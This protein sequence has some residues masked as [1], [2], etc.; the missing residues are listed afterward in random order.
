MADDSVDEDDGWDR[1]IAGRD[2]VPALDARRLPV[3]AARTVPLPH[4]RP[5]TVSRID[6]DAADTGAH[7][8]PDTTNRTPHPAMTA[9]ELLRFVGRLMAGCALSDEET[10][11]LSLAPFTWATLT[12][13]A[14][15]ADLDAFASVDH[16]FVTRMRQMASDEDF[17]TDPE[18][19]AF[20]FADPT[21]TVAL[22]DGSVV[23]LVPGGASRRVTPADRHEYVAL[24]V[25]ARLQE[26]AVAC[27]AIRK[28]ML[29]VLP[30]QL[31]A[32]WSPAELERAVCGEPVIPVHALRACASISLPEPLARVF[33]AA[34]ELMT[35]AERSRMLR[36]ATGRQRL[37]VRRFEVAPLHCSASHLPKAASCAMRLYL[38]PYESAEACLAKLRTAFA[39]CEE[40]DNF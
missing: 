34:V 24:A 38:P 28:G 16:L 25:A 17:A 33:W 3:P 20:V 40:I 11:P 35:H 6:V 37:P 15:P 23:P 31:L 8:A 39:L 7:Q 21:F 30:P 29:D 4:G 22:S 2:G 27:A 10:I 19:F 12:S 9:A 5:A 32:L 26:S 13:G 1:P 36:F 18:Q 14:P